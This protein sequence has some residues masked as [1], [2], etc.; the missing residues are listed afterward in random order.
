MIPAGSQSPHSMRMFLRFSNI[1][2][3]TKVILPGA[4]GQAFPP[5]PR[6][7]ASLGARQS[8]VNPSARKHCASDLERFPSGK[9]NTAESGALSMAITV[10]LN[11][12]YKQETTEKCR[13]CS[14]LFA[15]HSHAESTAPDPA[16]PS[17][18]PTQQE[19]SP[20]LLRRVFQVFRWASLAILILSLALIL[21]R[22]PPPQVS[23]DPKA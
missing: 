2:L 15:Y 7:R 8:M 18:F 1:D 3:K 16:A 9:V 12:G 22:S 21:H 4:Q 6:W 19:S 20:G 13:K 23:S 10:C 14:T 5:P 17:N 11:C